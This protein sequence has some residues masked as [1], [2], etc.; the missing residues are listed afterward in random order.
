VQVA[1]RLP[2]GVTARLNGAAISAIADTQIFPPSD[3]I[4]STLNGNEFVQGLSIM[5]PARQHRDSMQAALGQ[6]ARIGSR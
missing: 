6:T 3:D 4:A 5:A 2:T 1:I